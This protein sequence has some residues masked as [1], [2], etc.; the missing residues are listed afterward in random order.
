MS[1]WIKRIRTIVRRR[2][3]E[4]ELDAELQFHLDMLAAEYVRRGAS[5]EVALRTARQTFGGV[6]RVKDDVRDTWLTRLFETFGQDVR[7]GARSLRQ[8]KGYALAVI[9][10]MRRS[11]KAIVARSDAP[12]R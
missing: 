12:T 3:M 7:Y 9:V 2:A 11:A 1:S 6:E 5:P 10:T 8:Q 4:H